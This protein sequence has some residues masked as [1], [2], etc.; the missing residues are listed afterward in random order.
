MMP[1]ATGLVDFLVSDVKQHHWTLIS[2]STVRTADSVP[3]EP[4]TEL[5]RLAAYRES[6]SADSCLLCDYVQQ[7]V[8]VSDRERIVCIDEEGGWV[9]VTPFWAVWPF[10][11]MRE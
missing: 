1:P 7:E 10:E 6:S 2:N 5:S 4:A 9:A 11:I 3:Q 8:S